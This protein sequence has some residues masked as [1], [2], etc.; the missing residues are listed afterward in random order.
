MVFDGL[1]FDYE[2]ERNGEEDIGVNNLYDEHD[3]QIEEFVLMQY[4]G[5]H[6]KNEKECYEGDIVFDDYEHFEVKWKIDGFVAENVEDVKDI[7]PFGEIA[8]GQLFEIVGNIY[9]NPE[10]LN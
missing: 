1:S 5:L 10:L 6:D 4:T 2:N 9:E 7:R 3:R 8:E